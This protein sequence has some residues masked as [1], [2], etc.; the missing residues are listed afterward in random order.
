MIKINVKNEEIMIVLIL[1]ID[2]NGFKLSINDLFLFY[3]FKVRNIELMCEKEK[4]MIICWIGII[5]IED[6]IFGRIKN[7]SVCLYN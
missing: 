6:V 3:F 1:K 4:M 7:S 2:L 5:F